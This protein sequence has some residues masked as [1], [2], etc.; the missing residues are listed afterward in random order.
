MKRIIKIIGVVLVTIFIMIQFIPRDHNE[1]RTKPVND[2]AKVY[3]V[4]GNADAILKRSCYDCHSN[5]TNYPWYAQVQP[6]RY[7]L[8]G[9]IRGGKAE[10]NF[11][12]FG[13]YSS[14]KQRSRLRAI[15][16]SLDEDSMPLP[17]YTMIH[18]SAMLSKEDKLQLANWVKVTS[19]SRQ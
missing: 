6:F 3:P 5:H 4:P 1:N 7:M 8:D 9:H 10:L 15:G 2:I 19:D 12:E 18:R 11:D 16:E 14:R 13:T 17:S